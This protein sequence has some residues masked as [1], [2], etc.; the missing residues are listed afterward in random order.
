MARYARDTS[1]DLT[2]LGAKFAANWNRYEG[3]TPVTMEQVQRAQ[4]LG[5]Q[6]NRMLG[7]RDVGALKDGV[8]DSAALRQR[9]WTLLVN[10]YA[11]V[12][13]AVQFVRFHDRD[14]DT[15]ART[16]FQHASPRRASGNEPPAT[17]PTAPVTPAAIPP[18]VDNGPFT[19]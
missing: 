3:K 14:A 17:A 2:T 12:Q 6:I 7:L 18:A 5:T 13:R 10:A 1:A 19:N 16:L 11:E 8:L 4:V 9:A 15:I